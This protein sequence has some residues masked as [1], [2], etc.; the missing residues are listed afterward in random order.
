MEQERVS[1]NV[2][3]KPLDFTPVL[4][5]LLEYIKQKPDFADVSSLSVTYG[6][7]LVSNTK[8]ETFLIC[9]E[10]V[11]ENA[12]P[13]TNRS[14]RAIGVHTHRKTEKGESFSICP[15]FEIKFN[16]KEL[17]KLATSEPVNLANFIRVFGH[18]L[19]SNYNVVR[20]FI[21]TGK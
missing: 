7:G 18:R 1:T 8:G 10:G 15:R 5:E 20:R 17:E 13:I 19:E 12:K 11:I 21:E 4:N 14:K 16:L 3:V 9:T 2:T 6:Y